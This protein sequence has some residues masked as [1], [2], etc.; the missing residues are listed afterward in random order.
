MKRKWFSWWLRLAVSSLLIGYFVVTLSK[1][2]GGIRGAWQQFVQ[3]FAAA[4]PIWLLAAF[5][6]MMLGYS[7]LT[8]RWKVLLAAQDHYPP[9]KRLFRFYIMS[10]FFNNFLPSTIGGDVLRVVHSRRDSSRGVMSLVVVLIERLSGFVAL[11]L[12]A[13]IGVLVDGPMRTP[14]NRLI[15][16]IILIL[17]V[18]A[19][20]TAVLCHPR[21]ASRWLPR[22]RRIV[23]ERFGERI[24]A[25]I[26][27]LW[28]YYQRPASLATCLAISLVFQFNMVVYYWVIARTL[29]R[30]PDF[31]DFLL[32]VPIM[33]FLLMTVPAI[34][35]LGIRTA[36]FRTLMRFPAA[37]ALAAEFV[38]LGF[39]IL[40]GIVGGLVY[41]FSRRP[42]K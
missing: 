41:V 8:L 35:G 4:Q 6:L 21:P 10:T 3:V 2:Y 20:M 7:L 27:S 36:G 37:F 15:S 12:I 9:Y 25:A 22:L 19:V 32:H 31:F 40:L 33:V 5:A 34:N 11:M 18:S 29:D 38:D 23:P 16:I 13:G 42:Q 28:V 1:R 26:E 30:V 14:R 24:Q 17:M 39:H